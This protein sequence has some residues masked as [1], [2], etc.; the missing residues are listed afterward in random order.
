[1]GYYSWPGMIIFYLHLF[2]LM[3][4]LWLLEVRIRIE[5]VYFIDQKSETKSN[6]QSILD[7]V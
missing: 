2:A 7:Q 5:P 6:D 3:G 4:R 1:M